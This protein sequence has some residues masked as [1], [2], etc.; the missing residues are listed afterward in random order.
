[1]PPSDA[2]TLSCG[3]AEE[4]EGELAQDGAMRV[5]P[6]TPTFSLAFSHSKSPIGSCSTFLSLRDPVLTSTEVPREPAIFP[7]TER[8]RA[9]QDETWGD[10]GRTVLRRGGRT[11]LRREIF[12]QPI[13]MADYAEVR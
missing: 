11:V 3:G 13:K 10:G 6:T 7:C 9:P 1:M 8:A 4:P 2:D 5:M 12:R